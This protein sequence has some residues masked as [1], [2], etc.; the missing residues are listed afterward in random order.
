M[1][2]PPLD[3]LTMTA[4]SSSAARYEMPSCLRLIPGLLDDVMARAPATLA[5]RTM[6]IAAIS[7]SDWMNTPPGTSGS[8]RAMYSPSSFCGV[9]G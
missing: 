3:M 8:L 2:G 7:L 9:I 6:L 5:P 4:G 1:P